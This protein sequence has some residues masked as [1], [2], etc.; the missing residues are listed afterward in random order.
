MFPDGNCRPR[1]ARMTAIIA[2][3]AALAAGCG[4]P[5]D[6][7]VMPWQPPPAHPRCGA[8][9]RAL[10]KKTLARQELHRDLFIYRTSP[11]GT[12]VTTATASTS[13]R[14]R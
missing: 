7:P 9:V 12:S 13:W 8:L 4:Q 5:A 2:A 1:R 14:P 11:M 6:P 10:M 3:I